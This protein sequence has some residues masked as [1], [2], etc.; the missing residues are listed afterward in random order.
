M[1]TL[2]NYQQLGYKKK[3]LQT[4]LARKLQVRNQ[5]KKE[6]EGRDSL[7]KGGWIY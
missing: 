2:C 4:L 5:D 7:K 1:L 3:S 6:S